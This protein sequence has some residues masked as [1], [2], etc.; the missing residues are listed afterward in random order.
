MGRIGF[1]ITGR[2]FG[3]L[4][5]VCPTEERKHGHVV[6]KFRCDCG[7]TDCRT[8]QSVKSVVERGY[9]PSCGCVGRERMEEWE[10]RGGERLDF[11]E[12]K[13]NIINALTCRLR[14][15][16]LTLSKEQFDEEEICLLVGLLS[17]YNASVMKNEDA[18]KNALAQFWKRPEVQKIIKG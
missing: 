16:N 6:W 12:T 9:T 2:R 8:I 11:D 13:E 15:L 18:V 7:N 17:F 3:M 14:H 4:T 5:A 10:S 1:D